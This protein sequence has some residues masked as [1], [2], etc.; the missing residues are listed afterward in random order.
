MSDRNLNVVKPLAITDA[1][2]IASDVAETDYAEW[3][4]TTT[5]ALAERVVVVARHRI[6]EAIQGDNTNRAP[7]DEPLYWAEVGMTNRWKAFDNSNSSQTAQADTIS[8]TIRPGA[9]VTS[10]AALNL[11]GANSLRIRIDHDTYGSLYDQTA[12]L[13]AQPLAADWWSWFFGQ[14]EVPTQYLAFGLPGIP[15]VQITVD[16]A[17]T[18]EL[19]VGVLLIGE[20]RDFGIGV[21]YGVKFG[22]RDYSRTEPNDYGERVLVQRAY[23]KT[24]SCQ[25]V[26][27]KA[28]VNPILTFFAGLR[29]T[30]CLW[31]VTDEFEATT[32]FGTA[33]QFDVLVSYPNYAE[34]QLELLGM[35]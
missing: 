29:A 11:A 34:C 6:Y 12:D 2:L 20:P 30:P 7:E 18:D 14:R 25:L 15:D 28:E 33:E 8:Y 9:V 35:I 32:I 19:A 31:V 22:I 27:E 23:A 1:M 10:L 26:L 24:L 17:G 21:P 3:N 13:S 4:G 16:L 5:Y